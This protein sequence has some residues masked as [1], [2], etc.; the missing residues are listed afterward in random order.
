PKRRRN[1][2]PGGWSRGRRAVAR[3][4]TVKTASP[5]HRAS[6]HPMTSPRHAFPA[7]VLALLVAPALPAA[8]APPRPRVTAVPA[9]LR[10]RLRLDPFYQKYTHL[11]GLPILSSRK[12]SD[13]G[14]LEAR[15]LIGRMLSNR[16]DVLRV[17]VRAGVRFVVMAPTEMTTDVPEQR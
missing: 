11:G 6:G 4:G 1:T 12:V 7:L 8:V 2:G 10:K 13:R 17:M 15:Y 3:P 14:L 9:E 5:D 16:P